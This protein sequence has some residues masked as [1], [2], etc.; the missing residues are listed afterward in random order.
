MKLLNKVEKKQNVKINEIL[1]N[2]SNNTFSST[3][4]N[5]IHKFNVENV[6]NDASSF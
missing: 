4:Q 1:N 3:Y 6:Y 2:I 5:L